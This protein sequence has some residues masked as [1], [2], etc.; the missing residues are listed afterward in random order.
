MQ[1]VLVALPGLDLEEVQNEVDKQ[2]DALPRGGVARL[3]LSH[4][5][6]VKVDSEVRRRP[7]CPRC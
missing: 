3:A 7:F 2:C 5:C 4:S 1:V 6:V